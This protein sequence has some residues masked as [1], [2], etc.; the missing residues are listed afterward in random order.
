M[1]GLFP[2]RVITQK[3]GFVFIV[4][5][6]DDT[7]Q[8]AVEAAQEIEALLV[9]AWPTAPSELSVNDVRDPEE[10]ELVFAD[11]MQLLEEAEREE[12]H[13][14][15]ISGIVVVGELAVVTCMLTGED[16][17]SDE[18]EDEDDDSVEVDEEEFD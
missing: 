12:A 10:A 14:I 15:V 7:D 1:S 4:Q 8:D 2:H 17:E 18:E 5:P 16:L 13:Q 6:A 9:E 3:E 11:I